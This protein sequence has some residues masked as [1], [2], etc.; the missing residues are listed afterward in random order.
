MVAGKS[1]GLGD[2]FEG[3]S[4][5]LRLLRAQAVFPTGPLRKAPA[6]CNARSERKP[7][8]CD[9]TPLPLCRQSHSLRSRPVN[10]VRACVFGHPRLLHPHPTECTTPPWAASVA[11]HISDCGLVLWMSKDLDQIR[12]PQNVVFVYHWQKTS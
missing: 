12:V 6:L 4:L 1:A 10:D 7:R 5:P 8:E 2:L 11:D 9:Q 3:H